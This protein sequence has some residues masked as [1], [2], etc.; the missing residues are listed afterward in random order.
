MIGPGGPRP[1]KS[2]S[3][4]LTA[5]VLHCGPVTPSLAHRLRPPI[6]LLL[7]LLVAVGSCGGKKRPPGGVRRDA[8]VIRYRLPLRENPVDSG[9]AFRCYGACQ[10]E[11]TPVGYLECLRKC[12]G[13]D[14]THGL[15]CADYEVPP[16]AACITARKLRPDEELAP[17]WVALGTMAGVLVAV[18]LASLCS[19]SSSCNN[20]GYPAWPPPTG[21]PGTPQ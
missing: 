1:V 4:A 12:P 2:A 10:P 16:Y 8:D 17:G 6:G 20:W 3:S 21:A 13:F 19:S 18:S 14:T 9:E 15:T 11:E 5:A 7:A